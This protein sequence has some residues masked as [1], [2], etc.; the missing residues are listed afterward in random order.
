[1]AALKY[2]RK[3]NEMSSLPGRIFINIAI[4]PDLAFDF[5]ALCESL[6]LTRSEVIRML[7]VY[8]VDGKTKKGE[9]IINDVISFFNDYRVD[10]AD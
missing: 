1:M 7:I 3:T 6:D 10:K 5:D 8:A 9:P 4:K 2:I